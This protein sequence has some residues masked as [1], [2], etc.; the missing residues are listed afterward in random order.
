MAVFTLEVEQSV[1]TDKSSQSNNSSDVRLMYKWDEQ[2][3]GQTNHLKF[4]GLE[5]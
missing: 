4:V 1:W 5:R 3:F 2:I